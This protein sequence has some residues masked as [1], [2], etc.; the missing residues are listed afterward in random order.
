M[1]LPRLAVT[2]SGYGGRGYK[3]PVTGDGRI[4][5]SVTTILKAEAK[6]AIAQWVA[7]NTA[8]YAVANAA[9]LLSHSEEWGYKYL[10]WYHSRKPNPDAPDLNI[11]NYHQGVLDDA[12][13]QGTWA[14]EWIQADVVPGLKYPDTL[15]ANQN[16]W[17]MVQAWEDWKRGREIEPIW[18]ESTV[19]NDEEGYAGT[20]DGMW[21]ID[22]V[23]YL[24]D[25]KTSR[26]VHGSAWMQLAALHAAP[27]AFV[28]QP[29]DSYIALRDWQKPVEGLAVI[30]VRPR[31]VDSKGVEMAPFVK[32]IPG[33]DEQI[34][35]QSFRGLLQYQHAQRALRQAVREREK[36][37]GTS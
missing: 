34:H 26:G 8:A 15:N 23:T 6:P 14:H 33:E 28:A 7:D 25:I 36:N 3:N 18:T 31:D 29:D 32:M 9:E 4:V 12:A 27:E 20:F 10:R 17:D 1:T 30:H 16:H 13:E 37:A 19:W 24:M 22:G 2:Q 11:L 21:R 5:P 35:L